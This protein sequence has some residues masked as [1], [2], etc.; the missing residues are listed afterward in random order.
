MVT[1]CCSVGLQVAGGL[2]LMAQALHRV[3]HSVG[4]RQE[5][6]AHAFAPRPG[7]AQQV[8]HLRERHQRLH[9]R[10]PGLVRHLAHRVIALGVR[11]RL[12]PLHRI[13]D[14][15]GIGRGHHDLREQRIRVQRDRR[16]HLVQ[17]FALE[18]RFGLRGRN[19]RRRSRRAGLR[20]CPGGR[21]EQ[22]GHHRQVTRGNAHWE[23]PIARRLDS[24]SAHRGWR[25]AF[26]GYHRLRT[27]RACS[28]GQHA[29]APT[30]PLPTTRPA[31]TSTS[32]ATT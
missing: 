1:F 12:R 28:H 9:A 25:R 23:S 18:R 15:A 13:G 5:R 31:P 8:Q 11:M 6:I 24:R 14:I 3:H 27:N 29:R 19:G 2:R 7:P 32:S 22:Q 17:L 16:H 4:L 20:R 10:I 30:D 26:G 21:D